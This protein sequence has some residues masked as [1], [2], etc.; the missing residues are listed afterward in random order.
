M[1]SSDFSVSICHFE[2]DNI[3][4]LCHSKIVLVYHIIVIED[5][6]NVLEPVVVD[7]PQIVNI[8]H[9]FSVLVLAHAVIVVALVVS[10]VVFLLV[11]VIHLV[12]LLVAFAFVKTFSHNDHLFLFS[13]IHCLLHS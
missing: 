4:N 7:F 11:L 13:L 1:S 12:I 3:V 8:V 2:F 5:E 6:V 10:A 9:Y